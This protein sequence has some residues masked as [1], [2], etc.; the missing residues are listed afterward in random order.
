MW[1]LSLLLFTGSKFAIPIMP[2]AVIGIATLADI[3]I[4]S[5]NH[6]GIMKEVYRGTGN[7]LYNSAGVKKP[8]HEL[9]HLS[10]GVVF[11]AASLIF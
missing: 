10:I 2:H 6:T 9:V 7:Q 4:H 8:A 3:P 11:I 5:S 1:I